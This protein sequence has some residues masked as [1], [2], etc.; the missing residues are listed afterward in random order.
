[1]WVRNEYFRQ[2][3]KVARSSAT[4]KKKVFLN[5]FKWMIWLGNIFTDPWVRESESVSE[6]HEDLRIWDKDKEE[7]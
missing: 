7:L 4:M 2:E 3:M 6:D 5:E 1:M